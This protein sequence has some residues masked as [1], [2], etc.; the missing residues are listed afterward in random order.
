MK[1]SMAVGL[2]FTLTLVAFAVVNVGGDWKITMQSPRGERT[3][4][5][6]IV[7]DG[8][9]LTVT[10]SSPRGDAT[11]EGTIKESDVT[12]SGTREGMN[13]ESYTITYT[14]KVDGDTMKGMVQRGNR[15]EMEWTASRIK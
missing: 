12:W 8:K 4:D 6:K 9:K 13:G 10:I 3:N 2:A 15:S 11:F 7:Q 1:K 14:G 5:M